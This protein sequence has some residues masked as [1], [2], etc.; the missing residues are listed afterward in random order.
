MLLKRQDCYN[1]DELQPSTL[2]IFEHFL[3]IQRDLND[4]Q[5]AA[6]RI[7]ESKAEE[8][9][10]KTLIFDGQTECPFCFDALKF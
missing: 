2:S 5:A 7:N 9:T 3:K 1:A 6:K 8:P 4:G 10:F